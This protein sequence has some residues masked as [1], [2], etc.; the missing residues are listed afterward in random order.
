MSHRV[1][2]W[3]LGYFLIS[4]LRR[5][6]QNPATILNAYVRPGMTVL[7]PGPGMGFFTLDLLRMVGSTG[8]VVAVDIQPKMLSRLQ[9]RATKAGLAARLDARQATAESMELSDLAGK[10]DFTLA[11]AV[12]HE[13]PETTNFFRQVAV[14]SRSGATLLLAEPKGHVS[15]EQFEKELTAAHQNGFRLQSRPDIARGLAACCEKN[16]WP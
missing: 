1:C 9:K 14:A 6:R 7:E 3:W 2:P 4:P 8:R 16:S 13:F 10:A 15:A 11:F 5:W 12:V